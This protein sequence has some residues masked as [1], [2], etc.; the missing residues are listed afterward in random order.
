VSFGVGQFLAGGILF[1][2]ASEGSDES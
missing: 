2:N 1:L